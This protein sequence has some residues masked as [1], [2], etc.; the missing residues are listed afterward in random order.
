MTAQT[1]KKVDIREE[2][3]RIKGKL[4]DGRKFEKGNDEMKN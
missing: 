1:F 2:V 4:I 3:Q